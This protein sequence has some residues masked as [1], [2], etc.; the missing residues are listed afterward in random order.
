MLLQDKTAVVYGATGAVGSAVARTFAREG[1]RVFLTGRDL[2]R[3]DALVKE[4]SAAGGQAETAE[5]DALDAESVGRHLD[6]VEAKSGTV[7]ISFNAIGIPQEGVQGIPITELSLAGYLHPITTYTQSHFITAS[8][9]ARKMIARRAGVI[10]MHTAEPGKVGVPLLGGMG[11]AWAAL[12]SFNRELSAE[13]ARYGVR[14]VCLRTT[15]M[16]ETPLIDEVFGIHA[17]VYG[18]TRK[19]FGDAIAQRTHRQRPTALTELAE[20][21]AFVASDRAAAMT[22]T[23]ANLTGGL[24]VD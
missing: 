8:A 16:E 20:V 13:C 5:V 6:A 11:P 24:L 10:L 12:E 3:L 4:L 21:T 15:G 19:E 23:V 18:Q 2:A 7:D 9:A 14:A 1:A 22:G 17:E